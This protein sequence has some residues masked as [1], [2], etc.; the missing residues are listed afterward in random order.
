M[1]IDLDRRDRRV[2]LLPQSDTLRLRADNRHAFIKSARRP[3]SRKNRGQ[4]D[5]K[6]VRLPLERSGLHSGQRN[7]ESSGKKALLPVARHPDAEI[8]ARV[9]Q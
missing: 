1:C 3:I 4:R 9:K 6:G 2:Q 5:D 8:R 7:G